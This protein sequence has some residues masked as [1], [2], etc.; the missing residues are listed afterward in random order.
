MGVDNS[1]QALKTHRDKQAAAAVER[2]WACSLRYSGP[3]QSARGQPFRTGA[4]PW[5][6]PIEIPPVPRSA[7]EPK[8]IFPMTPLERLQAVEA[9]VP[10]RKMTFGGNE[11][12]N[13][14]YY[15]LPLGKEVF[16]TRCG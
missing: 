10:L 1:W 11:N 12:G 14:S 8:M 7:R 13:P 5:L 16:S 4:A 3:S 6:R 2:Q 15:P 9:P